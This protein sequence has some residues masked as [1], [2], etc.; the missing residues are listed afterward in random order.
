MLLKPNNKV[1]FLKTTNECSIDHYID[2]QKL[3]HAPVTE[4]NSCFVCLLDKENDLLHSD[5]A[6]PYFNFQSY[7]KSYKQYVSKL[8]NL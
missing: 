8:Y 4:Y 2:L 7:L 3:F 6:F 5:G 1:W